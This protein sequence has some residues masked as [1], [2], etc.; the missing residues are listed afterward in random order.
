MTVDDCLW[1]VHVEGIRRVSESAS[2]RSR[3]LA[4]AL[5]SAVSLHPCFGFRL[6]GCGPSGLLPLG[7]LLSSVGIRLL[8]ELLFDPEIL[9]AVWN[10][11]A[12]KAFRGIAVSILPCFSGHPAQCL[13]C[14][15]S[16]S[17]HPGG[18]S[19]V[20]RGTFCRKW[21]LCRIFGNGFRAVAG[22]QA[23]GGRSDDRERRR[24]VSHTRIDIS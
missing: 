18:H 5:F 20:S 11:L 14:F 12:L 17:C 15:C 24:M 7:S 22:R 8:I 10:P 6:S 13:F 16:F 4:H 2:R 23:A 9:S 3:N 21:T 1:H 19:S